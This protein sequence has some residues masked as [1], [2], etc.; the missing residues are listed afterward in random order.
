[1]LPFRPLLACDQMI[2]LPLVSDLTLILPSLIHSK[3]PFP[4]PIS[5]EIEIDLNFLF[6]FVHVNASA[7]C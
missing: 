5:L 4:M 6:R 3:L 7:V 1:M 2:G